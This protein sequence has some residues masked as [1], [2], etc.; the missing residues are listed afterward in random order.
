MR[1]CPQMYSSQE[2][3]LGWGLLPHVASLMVGRFDFLAS[4]TPLNSND[5]SKRSS[6]QRVSH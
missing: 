6:V 2:V 5:V 3:N 1:S 4:E